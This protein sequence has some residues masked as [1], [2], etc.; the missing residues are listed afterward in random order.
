[1]RFFLFKIFFIFSVILI[2]PGCWTSKVDLVLEKDASNPFGRAEFICWEYKKNE[3]EYNFGLLERLPN[4]NRYLY[5]EHDTP[6]ARQLKFYDIGTFF[7]DKRYIIQEEIENKKNQKIYLYGYLTKINGEWS[8]N[9]GMD[10]LTL[11]SIEELKQFINKNQRDVNKKLHKI[12]IRDIGEL[13]AIEI[14]NKIRRMNND[15]N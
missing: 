6:G 1:M 15:I 3:S 8:L 10:D 7:G 11:N 13:E 2:I 12:N 14:R 9:I 4:S 5:S